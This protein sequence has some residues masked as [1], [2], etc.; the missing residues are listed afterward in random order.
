M[1]EILLEGEA[2]LHGDGTDVDLQRLK[3]PAT[4]GF[5]CFQRQIVNFCALIEGGVDFIAVFAGEAGT[6][7]VD[8]D[9]SQLA[10]TNAEPLEIVHRLI[11]HGIHGLEAVRSLHGVHVP[12]V[13]DDLCQNVRVAF[14]LFDPGEQPWAIEVGDPI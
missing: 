10:L 9:I 8:G 2:L 4:H 12:V 6:V 11:Q 3:L 14:V 7:D 5:H 1:L 13:G